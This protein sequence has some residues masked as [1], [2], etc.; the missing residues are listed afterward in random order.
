MTDVRNEV[1]SLYCEMIDGRNTQLPGAIFDTIT[2]VD[3]C[4]S[5]YENDTNTY[6]GK[7]LC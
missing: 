3:G 7:S 6:R 1:I 2:P 4:M 5:G